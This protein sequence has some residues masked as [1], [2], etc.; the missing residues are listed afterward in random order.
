MTSDL[1]RSKEHCLLTLSDPEKWRDD[2]L[3]A[4]PSVGRKEAV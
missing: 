1:G 3:I 4:R 2:D